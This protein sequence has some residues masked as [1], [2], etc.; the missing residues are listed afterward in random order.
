MVY[1]GSTR[2][3]TLWRVRTGGDIKKGLWLCHLPMIEIRRPNSASKLLADS[4]KK[5]ITK[6]NPFQTNPSL[7][8]Q[9]IIL[10]QSQL[11]CSTHG[12]IKHSALLIFMLLVILLVQL[13]LL[14]CPGDAGSTDTGNAYMAGST[15]YVVF[16]VDAGNANGTALVTAD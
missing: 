16:A 12:G 10:L 4:P 13:L 3:V 5:E 11:C 14:L 15:F 1:Q 6:E 8:G 7:G 9:Q 2:T